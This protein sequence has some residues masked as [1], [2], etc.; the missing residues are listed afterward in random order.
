MAK[1]IVVGGGI[2]GL[3]A[4][5][6]LGNDGHDVTV[7]ER[8]P[9]PPPDPLAAW[10]DWD[11]RGVNQFRLVHYLQPRFR[12]LLDAELPEA[13]TELE[14]AG[15]L[16]F[17]LMKTIPS[18]ITGGFRPG[19]ERFDA[20]TARRPVAEAAIARVAEKTP[21]VDIRRGVGVAALIAKETPA[22][23]IPHVVGVRTEA[24]DE[25]RADVVVDVSGR[26][27]ALPAQLAA[28]GAR[29]PEEELEDSGFVYFVRHFRSDEGAFPPV[30]APFLAPCGTVSTLTLP[31]DNGAWG[32]GIVA[33]ASDRALRALKDCDT[34]MRV[35]RSFPLVAHWIDGE[36]IDGGK[37]AIMAHI[38]DRHRTFVL[39]GMP[40]AT[41]VL[42]VGDAWA[43]TNPSVGRGISIGMIHAVAMRALLR[44]A[45][46]D[47]PVAVALRWHDATMATAE[48]WYRATLAFDRHRLGEID[49]GLE[50][51]AYAP[52]DPQYEITKSLTFA[53]GQDPDVFRA[54]ASVITVLD[55]PDA[56]LAAP[57]V[58][59]KV[60]AL[61]A[62]WRDDP[63]IGPSRE[64]LL[65]IAAG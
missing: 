55:L 20:V 62:A 38:A 34:W 46:L 47:D 14:A 6:M 31:A 28:I 56:V 5:M 58:L 48:P 19:D 36:P 51:K 2:V 65:A 59:E 21:G 22:S 3:C 53:A 54:M 32:V 39:D 57:G 23:G 18:T 42:A 63:V 41:G 52:D 10:G 29:A 7:L 45:S 12:A 15:A 1:V 25:L 35:W 64:E 61:G 11:R 9:T 50:G 40:V 43:C 27:S 49:A 16:R 44:D 24:G 26:R 33:S 37:V 13:V 4:A 30:M 8:D 60:R 17:N